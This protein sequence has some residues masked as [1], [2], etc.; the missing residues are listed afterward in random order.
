MQQYGR[1]SESL[2]T[3]E[4]DESSLEDF[5]LSTCRFLDG[6]EMTLADFNTLPKHILKVV[7]NKYHTF[8]KE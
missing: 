6:N 1:V 3:D 7:A 4:T 8:L 2:L 5:T